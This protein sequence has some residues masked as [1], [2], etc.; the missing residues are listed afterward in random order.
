[1]LQRSPGYFVARPSRDEAGALSSIS[2]T[3]AFA[4]KRWSAIA[5]AIFYF[6]ARPPTRDGPSFRTRITTCVIL[7]ELRA[8]ISYQDYHMCCT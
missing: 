6:W 3:A 2:S 7:I 5:E 1:M 4:L 8:V